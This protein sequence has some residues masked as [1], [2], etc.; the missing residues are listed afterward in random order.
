[1][2]DLEWR[3]LC[4]QAKIISKSDQNSLG[5]LLDGSKMKEIKEN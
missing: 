5:G 2:T 4:N 3:F 1:M